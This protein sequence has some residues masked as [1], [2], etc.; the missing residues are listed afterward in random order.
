[1]SHLLFE[2]TAEDI[3]A[4]NDADARHL[5]AK[6]CEAEVRAHGG[7]A[8][9][10]IAGGAQTAPDG[11]SDVRVTAESARF[12]PGFVPR[13]S[14]VF[15]V[16]AEK[17]QKRR[18]T[19]EMRP[20]GVPRAILDELAVD[21]GAYVIVSTRDH[22]PDPSI[23][24]RV[25]AMRGAL[26][27]AAA[28]L[29]VDFY[30]AGRLTL[31]VQQH[32]GVVLWVRGR[33]GR[34]LSGWSP[35][36]PWSASDRPV[37]EAYLLDDTCRLRRDGESETLSLR[38]GMAAL[39]AALKPGEAVR[40]VGLSGHGKTRLA[41]ALFDERIGEDALSQGVAVYGDV[42]RGVDPNPRAVAEQLVALGRRAVLVVD[43]CPGSTHR[44]LVDVVRQSGSCVSVLT[45]EY[46]VGED[47][48]ENTAEFR[49]E[50]AS[51]DLVEALLKQRGFELSQT[52]RATVAA[53]A[54]GNARMAL[55]L[56]RSAPTRGSLSAL[57]DEELL[58]RL[59]GRNPG[60]SQRAAAEAASLV[61][62]L[63]LEATGETAE[64]PLLAEL[65]GMSLDEFHAAVV[66]LQ[67]RDLVQQRGHWRAVLPQA[68]AD[69]LARVTLE[70]L[71]RERVWDALVVRAPARLLSS[72]CHR[73]GRLHDLPAAVNLA[74]R[75]LAEGGPAGNPVQL[76]ELGVKAFEFL[77][78]AAPRAALE[79]LERAVAGADAAR[80]L[81][82]VE[83]ASRSRFVRIAW[84]LAYEQDLFARAVRVLAVF[85]RRE[86][87]D[88]RHDSA[89]DSLESLFKAVLSGTSA[90]PEV[91]FEVVD[92]WISD[93]E[94]DLAA[95]AITAALQVTHFVSTHSHDFGARQRDYGWLPRNQ[96]ETSAWYEG[97]LGCLE[98]LAQADRRAAARVLAQRFRE[99]WNVRLLRPKLIACSAVIGA[100]GFEKALWFEICE[101]LHY[102]RDHTHEE[103]LASLERLEVELRPSGVDELFRAH[104]LSPSWDWRDP[105]GG[106][107]M[108]SIRTSADQARAMGAAAVSDPGLLDRHETDLFRLPQSQTFSF[109]RG[110]A[111]CVPDLDRGWQDLRSRLARAKAEA[112]N[113][114]LIDGY[115][116]E[117]RSRDRELTEGWLDA[118]VEDQVLGYWFVSL[119]T[120]A[121][122]DEAAM[123]RLD[124]ALNTGI[125]PIGSFRWLAGGRAMDDTRAEGLRALL[126][127]LA[128][129]TGGF[130]YAIDIFGMRVHS[131]RQK[132]TPL[133]P[134][135]IE[136]GRALLAMA[137]FQGR[138]DTMLAH[139]LGE[140]ATTCLRGPEAE[141]LAR[142]IAER[143]RAAVLERETEPFAYQ[144]IATALFEQ[145][146][147][148][149]LDTFLA[150][151]KDWWRL[152]TL[153]RGL[154]RD[155]EDA[156]NHE[157]T[158]IAAAD[159]AVCMA[160]VGIAPEARTPRLADAIEYAEKGEN[161]L[162]W[163]QLARR[164]I[165]G[166]QGAAALHVF[167]DRFL[168]GV[169]WG[170]MLDQLLRRR[171]LLEELLSHPSA[172]VASMAKQLLTRL[173][174][175]AEKASTFDF[176]PHE[177]AFE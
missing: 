69:R 20:K 140:V 106:D 137:T 115:L 58:E 70:N 164:L 95:R 176:D 124:R 155:P 42:G 157:R 91:R 99:A 143:L 63:D 61:V 128:G 11:G 86:P 74:E 77:A 75:L 112:N 103:D 120:A 162:I 52:D 177:Q 135:I 92:A 108:D 78:P 5:V 80:F 38:D 139:H 154:N 122:I 30:D 98:H 165:D 10:L 50:P 131:D 19:S 117:A 62:S 37:D 123:G 54:K 51:D 33:L 23:L 48:F 136:I 159:P 25:E 21:D 148:V 144:G 134:K 59:F 142:R 34:N 8:V 46:D 116:A 12:L 39:R 156:G 9:G 36:G 149:A 56:A 175:A 31:W 81:S 168:P 15:Q 126:I 57:K 6:L 73:L 121:G 107:A 100:A 96:A 18:I 16:K 172:E 118:A 85:A 79:A 49:L 28:G 160:W 94:L 109:G 41:Q 60:P 44:T 84:A 3:Q 152:D 114:S 158:P 132:K 43:N 147:M 151:E 129:Q 89:R 83:N 145:Q 173:R 97:A 110:Y 130:E 163:T 101:T 170:S 71:R 55:A 87:E 1:M 169:F 166:P 29:H 127:K 167:A 40:L 102:D 171:P 88:F 161:R 45:V 105:K 17:M 35:Y 82:T 68:L 93:G 2:I 66:G 174:V 67:R 113:V 24:S 111:A 119:Q 65:A 90:A 4:L 32:P 27:P 22:L 64:A 76:S 72:F 47:D 153:V 53:F 7:S 104:V 146:P 26:A 13:V 141:P 125:A 133:D 150:E 138:A 14:T